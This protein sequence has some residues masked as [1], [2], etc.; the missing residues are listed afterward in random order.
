MSF[1]D[2]ENVKKEY[3]AGDVTIH[4]YLK[5]GLTGFGPVNAAVKVLCLTAWL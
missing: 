2:F 5:A 4:V 3:T 1:I